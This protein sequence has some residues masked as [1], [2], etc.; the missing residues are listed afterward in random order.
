MAMRI[1]RHIPS[2]A[3]REII[4]ILGSLATCDPS[5]IKSTIE[6]LKR[7][8]IWCSVVGL[9]AEVYICKLLSTETKGSYSVMLDEQHLK[10]ILTSH[11]IPA[12][13]LVGTESNLIRMG[14]PD[15]K[16]T[17]IESYPSMCAC[18]SDIP[19]NKGGKTFTTTGYFC[20]QCKSKY[21]SLPTE[22]KICGLPLVTGP[23]LAR[24]YQHLFP[25]G[26]F[27]ETEVVQGTN[28]E[29]CFGCFQLLENKAYVCDSCEQKFC[30]DCDVLLHESV[31]SC[32]GCTS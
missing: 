28:R 6:T 25:L 9:V 2:H 22:C 27:R 8:H 26:P 24:T 32:P 5:N 30:I 10:D 12:P 18:H 14:F 4:V 31:Q 13:A 21:C 29:K 23:Q 20:P 17:P 16:V 15:H 1:L 3:S 19:K 7:Y 11:T